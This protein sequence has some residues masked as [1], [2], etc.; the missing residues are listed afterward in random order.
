VQTNSEHRE[1]KLDE[2]ISRRSLI[3]GAAA[4]GGLVLAAAALGNGITSVDPVGAQVP[5]PDPISASRFSL[6]IDGIEIAAFNELVALTSEVQLTADK[7]AAPQQLVS[8]VL[9]RGQTASMELWAWH[10]AAAA[11]QTAASRKTCSIV[12]YGADG[13]PVA[14]YWLTNAWPSKLAL[15]SVQAG[16]AEILYEV[17]TI[18]ADLLQRVAAA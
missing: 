17:L 7:K 13:S 3:S 10:A 6:V 15:D 5:G 8:V 16:S 14:R 12:M 9:K 2:T 4:A 18:T 11:G 1:E